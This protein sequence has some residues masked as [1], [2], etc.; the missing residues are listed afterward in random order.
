MLALSL[1]TSPPLPLPAVKD[2]F[3]FRC[4]LLNSMDRSTQ[5]ANYEEIMLLHSEGEGEGVREGVEIVVQGAGP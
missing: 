5:L 4:M 1:P 2:Q 3:K